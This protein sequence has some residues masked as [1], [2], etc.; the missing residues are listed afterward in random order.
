[1]N[2]QN[3]D[4]S[5]SSNKTHLNPNELNIVVSNSDKAWQSYK[6]ISG[7]ER[8]KFLRTIATEIENVGDE[9]VNTVMEESGLPEGRVRGE[10]GRTCNQLRLFAEKLEEGSWFDAI[11]DTAQPDRAPI[12]KPDIRKMSLTSHLHFLLLVEILHQRLQ[13][14]VLLL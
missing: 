1:M 12:P 2:N 14:D 6:A 8:A 7:K 13:Q 10:R 4:D 9:L 5:S 3:G 11:I